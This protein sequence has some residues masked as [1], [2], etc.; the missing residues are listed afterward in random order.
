[1]VG[2][3]DL[4]RPRPEAW[5]ILQCFCND[6]GAIVR[7]HV[8]IEVNP[9]AGVNRAWGGVGEGS[10]PLGLGLCDMEQLAI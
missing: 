1:M 7:D 8:Q 9:R 2:K 10:L 5:R 6:S 4:T 3:E